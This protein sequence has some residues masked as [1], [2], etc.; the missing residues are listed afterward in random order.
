MTR[1]PKHYLKIPI[2]NSTY[3]ISV[4]DFQLYLNFLS[5]FLLKC[6][7]LNSER[8]P[9]IIEVSKSCP[10]LLQQPNY[11]RANGM[12][13]HQPPSQ[14]MGYPPP[15]QAHVPTGRLVELDSDRVA[16]Q[17]PAASTTSTLRQNQIPTTILEFNDKGLVFLYLEKQ[18]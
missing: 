14:Q 10:P 12:A 16:G 7:S 17:S 2:P 18:L 8:N 5:V 4:K 1:S 9:A 3:V 6:I 11:Y 15:G 13:S